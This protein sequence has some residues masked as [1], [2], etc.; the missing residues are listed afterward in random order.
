MGKY[1]LLCV[2]LRTYTSLTTNRQP[3]PRCTSAITILQRMSKTKLCEP[4]N[5]IE[6][7]Y[8]LTDQQNLHTFLY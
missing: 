6:W 8:H 1:D 7:L 4:T 5:K 3:T 2:I